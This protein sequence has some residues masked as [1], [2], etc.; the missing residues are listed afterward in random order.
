MTYYCSLI[1]S[2]R[3]T[4]QLRAPLPFTKS[5]RYDFKVNAVGSSQ[6]DGVTLDS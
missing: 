1:K 2:C 3:P 6:Y 4:S 5:M